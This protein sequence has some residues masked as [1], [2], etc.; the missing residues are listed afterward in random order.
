MPL[1]V[2]IDMLALDFHIRAVAQNA[3]DH[4]CDLA[5]NWSIQ[6]NCFHST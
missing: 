5:E 1:A 6:G 4:G 2:G 3:L